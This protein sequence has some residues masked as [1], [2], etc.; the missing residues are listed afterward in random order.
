MTAQKTGAALED[1][2]R[3]ARRAAAALEIWRHATGRS[4]PTLD[5][6]LA[7]A[8][9]AAESWHALLERHPHAEFDPADLWSRVEQFETESR[10]IIPAVAALLRSGQVEP[11]GPLVA[12]S[13]RGAEEALH[14]QV[15]QTTALVEMARALG[16]PAAST[17]GAGF[18]GSVWAIARR[19]D[20]EA[21]LHRW[22]QFYLDRF[23]ALAAH[24]TFFP[25]RAGPPALFLRAESERP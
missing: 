15:P 3:V 20:A 2:N 5:S 1:Y 23:P 7:S 4:D 18:G 10:E 11:I 16:C 21:F 17:F 9:A 12:R 14:N 22:R 19:Y 24:A 6:A 25:T 13:Q 8:P